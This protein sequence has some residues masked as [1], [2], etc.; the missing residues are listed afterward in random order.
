VS[1]RNEKAVVWRLKR[2]EKGKKRVRSRE[3]LGGKVKESWKL[4]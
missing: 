4:R 1:K 2:G 3:D